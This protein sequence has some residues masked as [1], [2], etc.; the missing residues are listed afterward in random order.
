MSS[1]PLLDRLVL[2][3]CLLANLYAVTIAPAHADEAIQ[4]WTPQ[5]YSVNGE[6][7]Y[8]QQGGWPG[9]PE[10]GCRPA[11]FALAHP[12][13]VQAAVPA[14]ASAP[15]AYPQAGQDHGCWH[16]YV[17]SRTRNSY[18]GMSTGDCW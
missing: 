18:V 12:I 8:C 7:V 14:Y 11:S 15:P 3:L 16:S 2:G 4:G 1:F 5:N 13:V 9:V 6:L 17:A 10:Y